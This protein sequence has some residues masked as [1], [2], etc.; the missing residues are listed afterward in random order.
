MSELR[1][2]NF[3]AVPK[4]AFCEYLCCTCMLA[5]R[6]RTASDRGVAH[7]PI[8]SL[9]WP[10]S[11]ERYYVML[12]SIHSSCCVR[13]PRNKK[14]TYSLEIAIHGPYRNF[15]SPN[16]KYMRMI[17]SNI[18]SHFQKSINATSQSTRRF[19]GHVSNMIAS[20]NSLKDNF[21]LAFHT[22][23]HTL[24]SA[25]ICNCHSSYFSCNCCIGIAAIPFAAASPV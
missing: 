15:A 22:D 16:K 11:Y 13:L 17:T 25:T 9:S 18:E 7:S 14:R 2:G 4:G 3:I 20:L 8:E 19:M 10:N 6:M 24:S 1:E 21:Y 12:E 23:T 5:R